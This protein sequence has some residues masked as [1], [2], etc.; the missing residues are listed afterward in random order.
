LNS[1][2]VNRMNE[3][4]LLV[5]V[6]TFSANPRMLR[7]SLEKP[8]AP[9]R[10]EGVLQRAEVQNQNGRVYPKQV[11]M[12]EAQKYADTFIR[13]RRA[14]GELD[15]PDSCLT[16]SGQILTKN[17]WKYIK[18]I[19]DNEEVLTLN[20]TTNKP[21]YNTINKKID[22]AYKGKMYHIKGKNI[23][24]TVTPN[25]RFVI[26]DRYGKLML[27]TAA[28]LYD[29]NKSVNTHL[30]IPKLNDS[31]YI[32]IDNRFID[33]KEI[34]YDDRIYC[35][36]V[37]NETFYCRDNNKCFWSGNSV[38]NLKNV[39]HNV[40]GIH[41]SGNDLI[42]TVEVLTTPSGNIL[43]EL[44]RNGINVGISSRALGSLNKISES[45]SVVGEDLELIAFDF[46]SNPSTA[47][48]FM[49]MKD[50]NS[51]HEGVQKAQNP[52]NNKWESINKI[53]RDILSNIG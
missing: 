32:H 33:I 23:D 53:V 24:T 31:N 28:E 1:R 18:D 44:F 25:H 3:R 38:V 9:F 4:K 6:Q 30:K 13:E 15:H 29:L 47:G 17:G 5:E 35:V 40:I 14:L 46:V 8:N 45:T 51:L 48:A 26:E 2:T 50:Q 12:R 16:Q 20:L 11:L 34:D 21:E 10:V 52:V 41:W 19:A 27:K 7:E 22:S 43:R 49:F 42:G 36:S 39:S 37:S